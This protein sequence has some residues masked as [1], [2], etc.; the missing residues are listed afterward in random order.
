MIDP[1]L[2][3]KLLEVYEPGAEFRTSGGVLEFWSPNNA[4]PRP[5]EAD[6]EEAQAV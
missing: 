2:L 1:S 3:P 5:T 4:R 6:M